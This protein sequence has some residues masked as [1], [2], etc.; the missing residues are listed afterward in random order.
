MRTKEEL[1]YHLDI[2]KKNADDAFED[3]ARLRGEVGSS[4]KRQHNTG[5]LEI[6]IIK[7]LIRPLQN[8]SN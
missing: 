2:S 1:E 5:T 6:M 3:V 7:K 4:G 8:K